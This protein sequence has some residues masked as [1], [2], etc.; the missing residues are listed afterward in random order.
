[1]SQASDGEKYWHC[2]DSKCSAYDPSSKMFPL[3][4]G[5]T[6]KLCPICGIN[7]NQPGQQPDSIP[8]AKLVSN[9]KPAVQC[10]CH[11]LSGY[12]CIDMIYSF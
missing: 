9:R 12:K 8:E 6:F 4:I 5:L 10:D 1:M 7:T 11:S 2:V 3:S